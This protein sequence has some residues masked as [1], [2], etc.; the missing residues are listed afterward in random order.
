MAG[1]RSDIGH[2][3]HRL[4]TDVTLNA[5]AEV[6]DSRR[7]IIA[8]NTKHTD[9]TDTERSREKVPDRREVGS[10]RDHVRRHLNHLQNLIVVE[11]VEEESDSTADRGLAIAEDIVGKSNSWSNLNRRRVD[12]ALVDYGHPLEWST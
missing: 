12:D 8:L 7:I 6:I 11:A 10:R 5:E 3:D 1:K 4:E 2:I 9:R